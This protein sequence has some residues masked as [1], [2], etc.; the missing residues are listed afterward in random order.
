MPDTAAVRAAILGNVNSVADIG[1][2]NDFERYAKSQTNMLKLYQTGKQVLGWHLT[3]R[4]PVAVTSI[5]VGRDVV[6][7]SWELRGFMSLDDSAASEKVFDG[8]VENIRAAM[9]ADESLGG[10]AETVLPEGDAG[11]QV[12]ESGPVM[13]AGVLCHSAT[14]KLTTIHYE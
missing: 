9:R 11:W 7:T 4:A 8:H 1:Q 6:R 3:R 5:A 12:V 10:V 14:L 13:F 2:V